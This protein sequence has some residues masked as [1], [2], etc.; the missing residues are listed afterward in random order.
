MESVLPPKSALR[1]MQPLRRA[2]CARVPS[3]EFAIKG[4]D[5]IRSAGSGVLNSSDFLADALKQLI[6]GCSAGS[7]GSEG[8]QGQRVNVHDL[9]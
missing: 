5:E 3:F 8:Y 1:L 6:H 2:L 7:A 9:A 4:T